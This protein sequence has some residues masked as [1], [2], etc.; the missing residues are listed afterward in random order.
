MVRY[1]TGQLARNQR[2]GYGASYKLNR[3]ILDLHKECRISII[4]RCL[5]LSNSCGFRVGQ[6]S[7]FYLK[8]QFWFADWR[9]GNGKRI[10]FQ[11]LVSISLGKKNAKINTKREEI[12]I[13]QGAQKCLSRKIESFSFNKPI[14][15]TSEFVE[16]IL[17]V[18]FYFPRAPSY[19]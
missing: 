7:S 16:N 10:I 3:L 8:T 15:C 18:K 13:L 17:Q 11:S 12:K 5:S 9:L 6:A 14:G 2:G 1:K 19:A 4:C